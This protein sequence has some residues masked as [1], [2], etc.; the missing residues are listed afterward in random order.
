MSR[1]NI[2][3]PPIALKCKIIFDFRFQKPRDIEKHRRIAILSSTLI[4]FIISSLK[5]VIPSKN[6]QSPFGRHGQTPKLAQYTVISH[7]WQA[8]LERTI[9]QQISVNKPR[10]VW[11]TKS[12]HFWRVLST[13]KGGY[14]RY[15]LWGPSVEMRNLI[16]KIKGIMRS[17]RSFY[18]TG[19]TSRVWA[20]YSICSG[21]SI[22]GRISCPTCRFRS[23]WEIMSIWVLKLN[24]R[25]SP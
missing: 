9:W 23:G 6:K 20:L 12:V 18:Q 5:D 8:I 7:Q 4:Q 15:I 2:W 1:L 13:R 25:R 16:A 22:H 11:K 21:C 17:T 19:I 14:I 24:R 3:S 10:F